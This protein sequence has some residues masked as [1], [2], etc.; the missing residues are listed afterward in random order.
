MPSYIMQHRL[1]DA[2]LDVVVTPLSLIGEN[3]SI[4]YETLMPLNDE[5]EVSI[6]VND[7]GASYT[8]QTVA[9]HTVLLE[10][11]D[12]TQVANVIMTLIEQ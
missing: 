11:S 10:T 8:L 2:L 12:V 7:F 1:Q 9:E 5:Y 3:S 4:Q 6:A